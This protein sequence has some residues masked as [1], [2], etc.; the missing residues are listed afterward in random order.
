MKN[1]YTNALTPA[2]Q[3]E[4]ANERQTKNNAGGFVYQVSDKT[5][6]E[7]FLILGTPGGTYYQSEKDITKQNV[8]FL[9]NLIKNDPMLV[10]NTA[11]EISYNGRAYKNSPSIFALAL[12]FK[13][14]SEDIKPYLRSVVTKVCRTA[15]HLFELAEYFEALGGWSRAK[16]SAVADWYNQK[17]PDQL[18][19]QAVKYRQ[20]N[21]WTHKDLFRLVH[22]KGVDKS[23]GNFIL[24]K[25]IEDTVPPIIDGFEAAQKAKTPK[26]ALI[27]L[28]AYKNLPW[29][30]LPTELHKSPEIWKKL[31][32]NGQLKGQALVRNITRLARIGA[33]NDMMFAK[34][35]ADMLANDEQIKAGRLHPLNYL[36]AIVVHTEGQTDRRSV[37]LKNKDWDTV[38]VIVDA[39]NA[40]FYK[41]FNYV[42]PAGKRFMLGVDVSGSMGYKA[43]GLELSCA[44]VAGAMAMAIAKTEPY[45]MVRGFTS[46]TTGGYWS[47]GDTQLTDLGITPNMDLNTVMR[48]VQKNNFGRT[49]CSLPMEWAIQ[50]KVE[51]DTFVVLTDNETYAGRRHPDEALRDYRR[52][53]GIDARLIVVGMTA[54]DFTIADP[55]DAGML[56]VVG[57]DANL[58]RLVSD[59]SAGRL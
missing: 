28:E 37:Y 21:G 9:V 26:G 14:G 34:D 12:T 59:F 15:T 40:G 10:I 39:L 2:T 50:N 55:N 56:D 4:K 8:D 13:H 52:K 42:E 7:R 3:T 53:T 43:L 46:S 24:G 35:Y 6:L 48:N 44:Q 32:Y 1:A 31:F 20:R 16:R 18:A 27:V 11:V 33:F 5:R 19:Y 51:I 30:A 57:A 47:R 29:E 49:D 23:V 45:Y 25:P 22:P 54:T 38:P 36:N 58:P 41:A 17:T